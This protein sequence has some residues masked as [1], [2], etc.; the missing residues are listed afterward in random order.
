VPIIATDIVP[1]R[2]GLPVTLVDNRFKDWMKAIQTYIHDA[3]FRTS[4]GDALRDA[5]QRDWYLRDHGLDEW[6]N[7]W[8]PAIK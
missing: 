6:R 5:I 4:Q 7:S 3:Q 2:C 1:Y 8:L